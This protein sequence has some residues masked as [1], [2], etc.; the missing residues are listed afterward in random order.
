MALEEERVQVEAVTITDWEKVP[1][2]LNDYA[3]EIE[4]IGPNPFKVFLK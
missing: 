4:E 1:K 2:I 3:E